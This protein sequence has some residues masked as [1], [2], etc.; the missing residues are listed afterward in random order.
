MIKFVSLAEKF[1]NKKNNKKV[2]VIKYFKKINIEET[3]ILIRKS[4]YLVF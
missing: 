1:I 2:K 3:S 4:I